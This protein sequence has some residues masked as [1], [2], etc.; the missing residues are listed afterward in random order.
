MTYEKSKLMCEIQMKRVAIPLVTANRLEGSNFATSHYK[1]L[2]N[3]FRL[4]F[5][6]IIHLIHH[7][8][9]I[10]LKLHLYLTKIHYLL[11]YF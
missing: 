3:Q 1:E 11:M 10:T 6:H 5:F 9:S 8:L 2:A 7:S 4:L